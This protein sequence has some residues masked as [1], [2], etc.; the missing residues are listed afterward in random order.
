MP[1]TDFFD[2]DLIQ[3]REPARPA[4]PPPPAP[5]N[6]F[7]TPAAAGQQSAGGSATLSASPAPIPRLEQFKQSTDDKVSDAIQEIERLRKRQ[8]ELDQR[9]RELESIRKRQDDY[10][11]GKREMVDRLS[12]SLVTLEKGEVQATRLVELLGATRKRFKGM[13]QE[14]QALNENAW[15][16]DN[17][18]IREELYKAAVIIDETRMEYNK[19]MAKIEA[20]SL[21]E[22]QAIEKGAPALLEQG[23]TRTLADEEQP[24]DFVYWLKIGIAVTL[25][26]LITL[27]A[28]AIILLAIRP[29]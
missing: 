9:R 25:P 11:R 23:R 14:I 13:L 18:K 8:D 10:T 3:N 22:K 15:P 26:L 19:S 20:V 2:E 28:L 29:L 5:R 4:T 27:I 1:N 16:A 17:E 21:S 6:Q 24:K 7:E 12:E